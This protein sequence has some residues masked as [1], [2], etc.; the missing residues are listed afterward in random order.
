M[1]LYLFWRVVKMV[2]IA[3]F[4]AGC[5]AGIVRDPDD[6]ARLGFG[7]ST[8]GWLLS[9]TAGWG[10]LQ[11]TSVTMKASWVS[12]GMLFSLVAFVA[13]VGAAGAAKTRMW[14][15]VSVGAFVA[16]AAVMTLKTIPIA[17]PASLGFGVLAAVP[18]FLLARDGEAPSHVLTLRWFAVIAW[19][20]GISLLALFGLYMPFKYGM[21]IELDGGQKWFGWTH[22]MLVMG[23]VGALALTAWRARWS[24]LDVVL[25]FVASFLPFGTFWFERRIMHRAV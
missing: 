13:A 10:L 19:L 15:A 16:S 25:G 5:L 11:E 2:G 22:G 3:L 1:S 20:E 8:L 18:A 17:H 21:H 9:W 7:A 4:G 12:A 24:P 6:R 23:Y 14:T